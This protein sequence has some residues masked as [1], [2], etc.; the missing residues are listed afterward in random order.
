MFRYIRNVLEVVPSLS[1][2]PHC[3][4]CLMFLLNFPISFLILFLEPSLDMSPAKVS[5]PS[6]HQKFDVKI[7]ASRFVSNKEGPSPR[8]RSSKGSRFLSFAHSLFNWVV[9]NS[10]SNGLGW[11]SPFCS[12]WGLISLGPS[13]VSQF[14]YKSPCINSLY[15]RLYVRVLKYATLIPSLASDFRPV[16]IQNI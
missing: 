3:S 5:P 1:K 4:F 16:F 6:L 13:L 8:V 2:K 14:K 11:T 15:Q 7:E 9:C 10:F 12:S